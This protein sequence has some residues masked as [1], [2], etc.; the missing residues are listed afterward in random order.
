MKDEHTKDVQHGNANQSSN[1]DEPLHAGV[2]LTLNGTVVLARRI[3]L[4]PFSGK[5]P[6]FAGYWSV[7]CGA[8]E[9]G[10]DAATAAVREVLEETQLVI[11]K[12]KLQFLGKIRELA[13]FR[14]E[15]KEYQP[16]ELDYEHTEYGYF[17]ISRMHTSPDPVDED[18]ARAIQYN[19]FINS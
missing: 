2:A 17:K 7:F 3:E 19:H 16:I 15:L 9:E 1:S 18:I 4:C 12:D 5:K 13:L 11:D 8:I 6:P 14:Y 10:E